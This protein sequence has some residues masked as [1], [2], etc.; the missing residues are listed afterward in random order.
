MLLSSSINQISFAGS[1]DLITVALSDGTL[2]L[3]KISDDN[4]IAE[5]F[6]VIQWVE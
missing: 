4:I 5:K 2:N 3:L 6:Q 1:S